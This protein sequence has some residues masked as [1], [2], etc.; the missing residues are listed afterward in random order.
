MPT[1]AVLAGR[2]SPSIS[3]YGPDGRPGIVRQCSCGRPS[4][5]PT[6]WGAAAVRR[7]R[8]RPELVAGPAELD[9]RLGRSGR[10]LLY[11]EERRRAVVRPAIARRP[12][13]QPRVAELLAELRDVGAGTDRVRLET[14][15]RDVVRMRSGERT[16]F[17]AAQVGELAERLRDRVLVELV[18]SG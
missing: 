14:E 10:A 5:S 16:A 12:A 17:R 11:A 1:R 9:L 8:R 7:P 2:C 18:R 13:D 15:L 3:W 6:G 4:R